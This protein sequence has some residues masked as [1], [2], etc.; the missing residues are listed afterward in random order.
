M[1]RLPPYHLDLHTA[2]TLQAAVKNTLLE[3]CD[4]KYGT[5]QGYVKVSEMPAN[6]WKA[7]FDKI[8]NGTRA[9]CQGTYH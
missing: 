2:E 7:S 1:Y 3:T 8:S 4:V 6:D 9:S 5:W